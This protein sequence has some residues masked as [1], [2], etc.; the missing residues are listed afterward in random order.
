MI[1]AKS[2]AGPSPALNLLPS[3]IAALLLTAVGAGDPRP[4]TLKAVEFAEFE[5]IPFELEVMLERPA[6]ASGNSELR[7]GSIMRCQQPLAELLHSV[8]IELNKTELWLTLAD[9]S[10][11]L[12]LKNG[13]KAT[14]VDLGSKAN[15]N[16]V[17]FYAKQ[18]VWFAAPAGMLRGKTSLG[19]IEFLDVD[20]D[21]KFDSELDFIAWR[22]GRLRLRGSAPTVHSE[23]ALHGVE[24]IENRGKL[25]VQLTTSAVPEGVDE[26]IRLAWVTANEFRNQ[27]GLEPVALDLQRI[28]AAQKHS[29][30][31]QLNGGGGAGEL[32]VHD[33][34]STLPGYTPEGKQAANGNVMWKSSGSDLPSQPDHE[35]ATLF[36]RSEYIYPSTTMGAG[37]DGGYSVVWMEAGQMDNARWLQ[38]NNMKSRWVMVPAAGQKTSP[39]APNAIIPFRPACQIFINNNAAGRFPSLVHINTAN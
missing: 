37:A 23:K 17:L 35:I 2:D 34:I 11:P 27:V 29:K 26:D 22:G 10:R 20:F 33:E 28:D 39:A 18:R 31:L 9:A 12:K 36:H 13:K 14:V 24:L 25:Q 1:G 30:Y 19:E 3:T 7:A 32:N 6:P 21:G 15:P 8:K 5:R 16:P 4:A 38:S